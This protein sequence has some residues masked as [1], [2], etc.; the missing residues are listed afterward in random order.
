MEQRGHSCCHASYTAICILCPLCVS[1]TQHGLCQELYEAREVLTRGSKPG[2][3][4]GCWN[5]DKV[6]GMENMDKELESAVWRMP[7]SILLQ[8]VL[9]QVIT[10]QDFVSE[11]EEK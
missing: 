10:I 6:M 2:A 9:F 7:G 3:C 8:T 4:K 1:S 11:T 5:P